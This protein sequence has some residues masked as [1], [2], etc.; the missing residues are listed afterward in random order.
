MR[1]ANLFTFSLEGSPRS[2]EAHLPNTKD[3]PK[4]KASRMSQTVPWTLGTEVG[5]TQLHSRCHSRVHR[6]GPAAEQGCQSLA[7]PSLPARPPPGGWHGIRRP[8]HASTLS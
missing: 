3:D 2:P 1:I 8:F 6:Q 7:C 5:A 4:L